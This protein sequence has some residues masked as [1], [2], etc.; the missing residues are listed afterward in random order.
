MTV[1]VPAPASAGAI[2]RL[3]LV[4]G[5][6]SHVEVLRRF[7]LDP[8]PD[9]RLS[10]I[11]RDL[12]TPYSGMLPGFLAGHYSHEE[13]HVDLRP[14]ARAAGAELIHAEAV[15]FDPDRKSISCGDGTA[16]PFDVASLDIGSQPDRSEIPGAAEHALPVKPVDRFLAG[17]TAIEA[18]V[19][20]ATARFRIVVVGGG[21]GGVELC[22]SLRHR[23][24]A[25]LIE[26]GADPERAGFRIVTR[27][28]EILPTHAP[29]VRRRLARI[30][31]KRGVTVHVGCSVDEVRP[32]RLICVPRTEIGFDALIWVTHAGAAA[33]LADSGLA[34]DP[35]GFVR[36]NDRLQSV[37]H[38]SVF[39]AGDAAAL[40][41]HRLAKSGV[42]AVRQGPPLA[43]NLRLA[44][45]G[46]PLE[47]YRPQRR[48]LALISTGDRY[49]IASRGG[50][51][52]GGA[53]LWWLKDR[54]DRRWMRQYQSLG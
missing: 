35:D 39:A 24:R 29:G 8:A 46:E 42:H 12:D 22:L 5:G 15:G 54:I 50:L 48:T 16:V 11:A 41:G 43:R 49:A 7:A 28:A 30:L 2:R 47:P 31:R 34:T 17:W 4:G 51:V 21:A 20:A 53:W 52:A 23:L 26:T 9:I 14:L 27:T 10:L 33:W 37:S 18:K 45:R 32:G 13:C 19:L 38:P 25:R 44:C 6:H 36:V 40:A 3:V 1:A